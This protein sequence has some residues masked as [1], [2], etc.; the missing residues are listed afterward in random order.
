MNPAIRSAVYLYVAVGMTLLVSDGMVS[1]LR[2]QADKRFPA[3]FLVFTFLAI[4]G[5]LAVA[6]WNSFQQPIRWR[7][8]IVFCLVAS[9]GILQLL[10]AP[11]RY[12]Y[13]GV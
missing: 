9:I 1:A 4:L 3:S 11:T 2:Y 8:W 7:R 6:N 5:L 13:T 10:F 12:G